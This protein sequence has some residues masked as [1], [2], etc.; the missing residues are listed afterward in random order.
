[1]TMTSEPLPSWAVLP[2][3]HGPATRVLPFL[4]LGLSLLVS[5][6][7]AQPVIE[8]EGHRCLPRDEFAQ[9]AATI[10]A[11]SEVRAAKVYFR[12]IQ[13]PDFYFIAMERMG[14]RF[15]T[16]LP[17]PLRATDR[18]VYYVEAVDAAFN[19]S[20]TAEYVSEIDPDC[21]RRNP[22]LAWFPG[23]SPNLVVGAVRSGLAQLP[24]G[25]EAAGISG[26]VSS[27]GAVTSAGGGGIGTG[28][29]IAAGAGAAAGAGV[30]VSREEGASTSLPA[31][32]SSTSTAP[33]ATTTTTTASPAGGSTTTS[34]VSSPAGSTSTSTVTPGSTT[35]PPT[36]T[37]TT[38]TLFPLVACFTVSDLDGAAG[39][40]VGFDARCS[41][42]NIASY[43]WRFIDNP[44]VTVMLTT[45]TTEHDWS[46]DP[47]CGTPFTRQVDLTVT[48]TN[49]ATHTLQQN[50]NPTSPSALRTHRLSS[51]LSVVT[52]FLSELRGG[53]SGLHVTGQVRLD[54]RRTDPTDSRVPF[55]HALGGTP[56]VHEVSAY[57][58]SA[59]DM[60]VWWRFDFSQTER[61]VSGSLEVQAGTVVSLDARSIVFR[62][63]GEAGEHL[64][65]TFLIR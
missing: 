28:V 63:R 21:R 6:A 34:T 61:F 29:A 23:S 1:M 18:V 42:G 51:A 65:F 15:E 10:A 25:F 55:R 20:R 48:A 30:L 40:R 5:S 47:A 39:C 2:P 59:A 33:R 26:F 19:V 54:D 43:T 31:S 56:A 7:D 22:T 38:S 53:P 41:Q 58:T 32:P 8:H 45:P 11:A 35:V 17:K 27:A 44:P 3:A 62:L 37:T 57:L 14:D 52:T 12:S 13:Y 9:I 50:I 60:P 16:Y 46:A 49:G 36:S 24:P 64:R 4:W